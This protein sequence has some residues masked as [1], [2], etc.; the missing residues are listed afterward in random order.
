MGTNRRLLATSLVLAGFFSL[1]AAPLSAAAETAKKD[2][3]ANDQKEE[4]FLADKN[5]ADYHKKWC[6]LL[7]KIK[8]ENRVTFK[9]K[10]E[11]ERKG[12][13]PCQMCMP[14]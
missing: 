3:K 14:F 11:A 2:A 1:V 9:S 8:Q 6:P 5:G 10:K 12:F 4:I 7:L 13:S